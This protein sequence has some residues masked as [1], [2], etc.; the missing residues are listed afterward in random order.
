M[1]QVI[2]FT[3][4]TLSAIEAWRELDATYLPPAAQGD[5]Y[6]AT[7][8][9]PAAIGLIDGYFERVPSVAHKEILWAMSQGIHV[10]GASSMGALRAAELAPFGMEGVGEIFESF[11]R[12]ELEDDDEVAVIHASA[13]EGYRPL[14]EAMVNIRATLASLSRDGLLADETRERLQHLAKELFFADRSFP[15]LLA[16]ATRAGLPEKD[17]EVLRRQL[18]ERRVDRKKLDALALLRTLRE[19]LAAGLG[20]KQVRY[21]FSHTDAWEFITRANPGAVRTGTHGVPGPYHG[22]HGS[23]GALRTQTA[24]DTLPE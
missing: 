18:P 12:G 22:D 14:S 6:E 1:N 23:R 20:P 13:E 24:P 15:A 10:F 8:R 11:Q 4:P 21:H 16:R 3:G 5:L 19:R 2:V 7:L 9:K 17:F